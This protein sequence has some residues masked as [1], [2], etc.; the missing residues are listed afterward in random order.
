M[1]KYRDNLC[2]R[3]PGKRYTKAK[4]DQSLQENIENI[5]PNQ[6]DSNTK[7]ISPQ[8]ETADK[9]INE[10]LLVLPHFLFNM[11]ESQENCQRCAQMLIQ[12]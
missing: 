3:D 7:L 11:Q 9:Y 4:L 8:D 12:L 1:P 6:G 5:L 2:G 10:N